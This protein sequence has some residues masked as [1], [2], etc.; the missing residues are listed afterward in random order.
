MLATIALDDDLLAEAQR[1]TGTQEK[2]AL[3]RD[4]FRA[5][6]PARERPAVGSPRWHRAS[7]A[8]HSA[9]PVFT[10]VILVDT[11]VWIDHLRSGDAALTRLL[12]T[13]L[14]LGHPGSQASLPSATSPSARRSCRS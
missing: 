9:A 12:D 2:T 14:A 8:G 11:S 1:L 6:I 7:A 4:A 13:G 5:L 10:V 3:V